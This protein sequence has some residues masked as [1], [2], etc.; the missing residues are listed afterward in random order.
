MRVRSESG[1]SG[2]MRS[3]I[4]TVAMVHLLLIRSEKSAGALVL[5][6]N[7]PAVAAAGDFVAALRAREACHFFRAD[8][9]DFARTADVRRLHLFELLSSSS[10]ITADFGR[11]L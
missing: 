4:T 5:G 6:D 11:G 9:V 3:V 2:M 1:A 8:D 10:H 7:A